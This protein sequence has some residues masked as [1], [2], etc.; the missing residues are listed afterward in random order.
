MKKLLVLGICALFAACSSA[1]EKSAEAGTAA[2]L[3]TTA[4]NPTVTGVPAPSDTA[5]TPAAAAT[6]APAPSAAA[7]AAAAPAP[8]AA[9]PKPAASASSAKKGEAMIGK[10]DC[11]V[12]HK[13]DV[14]IIG[15]AYAD[16]AKKY[17]NT[18][19]NINYLADK[20]VKGGSGVWGQV[21]MAPHPALSHDEAR[22]LAM[23]VLSI[24]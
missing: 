20:I 6:P 15:P 14:K 18:D 11:L 3:K 10:L 9:Q 5:K 1:P 21:P 2:D 8:V 13:L 23:Y 24:K 22:S 7:P 4:Q 16:V 17:S 19:A 12:C